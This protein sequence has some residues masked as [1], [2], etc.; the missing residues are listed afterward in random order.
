MKNTCLSSRAKGF[1]FSV[2]ILPLDTS[3]HNTR[4][5]AALQEHLK[6]ENQNRQQFLC[7]SAIE[8]STMLRLTD[9]GARKPLVM[10]TCSLWKK[11]P[12]WLILRAQCWSTTSQPSTQL[13]GDRWTVGS[14]GGNWT[15]V[16]RAPGKGFGCSAWAGAAVSS[17]WEPAMPIF[18]KRPGSQSTAGSP[19]NTY[20][21]GPWWLTCRLAL[22]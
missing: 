14:A 3:W 13:A 15:W 20:G 18:H 22:L 2:H 21:T 8:S 19:G 12:L 4:A 11:I 17:I 5:V 16:Y 9:M 10:T 6:K 1:F 7:L